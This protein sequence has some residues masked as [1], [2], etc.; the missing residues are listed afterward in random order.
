M[1]SA[2]GCEKVIE[3]ENITCHERE[4][5]FAAVKCERAECADIENR[6]HFEQHTQNRCPWEI[7][8]VQMS[9]DQLLLLVNCANTKTSAKWRRSRAPTLV[10]TTLHEVCDNSLVKCVVEGC[11]FQAKR[12]EKEK[13]NQHMSTEHI[14][15]LSQ[16]N[17]EMTTTQ[18][19][20][21]RDFL[22]LI[23]SLILGIASPFCILRNLFFPFVLIVLFV[24]FVLIVLCQFCSLVL[25]L[26][27]GFVFV[28][29]WL[30]F[31]FQFWP[32]SFVLF[33]VVRFILL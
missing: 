6:S 5:G 29:V 8:D 30:H 18:Q 17:Q 12:R 11:S 19:L 26:C 1:H 13:L 25:S 7:W 4:C 28:I 23:H 24:L 3:L 33:C 32:N 16:S 20:D 27:S 9:V 22:I 14:V 21:K 10:P 2:R 15:F 31:V